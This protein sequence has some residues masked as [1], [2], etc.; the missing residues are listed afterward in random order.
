MSFDDIM[1]QGRSQ[2]GILG[3]FLD[4]PYGIPLDP[5]PF[6]KNKIPM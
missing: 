5:L 3:C 2:G 4:N 1:G 6:L